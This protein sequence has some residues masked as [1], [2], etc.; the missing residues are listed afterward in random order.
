[1]AQI[2]L[3]NDLKELLILEM[4]SLGFSL[5]NGEDVDSILIKYLNLAIKIPPIIKWTIEE[6]SEVKAKN[7]SPEIKA[8]FEKFK[9]EAE[10]G[11]D[12]KPYLSTRIND[13]NYSDL[14]F[15]DWGIF[16]F[17]LGCDL[18]HRGFINRTNELLFAISKPNEDKLFLINIYPHQN[19][20]SNQDLL[21]IIEHNWPEIVD[22]HNLKGVIGLSGD[23]VSNEDLH[24]LR[25]AGINTVIQ[26]PGGRVLAPMGGGISTAGTS[27]RTRMQADTILNTIENIEREIL[28]KKIEIETVM[29]SKYNKKWEDLVINLVEFG[30]TITIIEDDSKEIIYSCQTGW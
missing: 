17:H 10:S 26:T 6:S 16:H 19:A 13:P 11:S 24:K 30:G 5:V 2:N 9:L 28:K 1:M 12:L 25:K 23:P 15:Y 20:F 8:G 18:D 3:L 21:A 7:L 22:R 14:M 27:V 29:H 4:N